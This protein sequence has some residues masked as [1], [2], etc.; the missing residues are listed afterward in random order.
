M[1]HGNTTIIRT[2]E[3]IIRLNYNPRDFKSAEAAAKGLYE[4]LKPVVRSFGQNPGTELALMSPKEAKEHNQVEGWW[5]IWEAGPFEWGIIASLTDF[6][7][8]DWWTEPYW[9]FDLIFYD[10]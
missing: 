7:T 2:D 3:G 8:A 10:D 6:H 1:Q 4:A 9:G 5:V